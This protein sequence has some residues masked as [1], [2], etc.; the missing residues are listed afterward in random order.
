MNEDLNQEILMELRRLRRS[1]NVAAWLCVILIAAA[2]VYMQIRL[3]SLSPTQSQTDSWDAVRTAMDHSDY[4]RASA[5]AGR[6]AERSP[7]DYYGQA[8][9]GNIALATG[10]IKDAEALYAR[11]V[12]LL[13][14]EEHEKV[15]N[16]IR[17]RLQND[18]SKQTG[19]PK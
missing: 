7:D 6:I 5:I 8:Y 1:G 19:E 9:L 14:T 16:A 17:K 11:V 3:H 12:E 13:P 15:L 2:V 4:T 18:A 10:R